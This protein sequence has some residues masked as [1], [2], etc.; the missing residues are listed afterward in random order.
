MAAVVSLDKQTIQEGGASVQVREP[1]DFYLDVTE[2]LSVAMLIC[3]KLLQPDLTLNQ[4]MWSHVY[5]KCLSNFL[6]TVEEF[7][8]HCLDSFFCRH[9]AACL[10]FLVL[11]SLTFVIFAIFLLNWPK[12]VFSCVDVVVLLCWCKRIISSRPLEE[13]FRFSTGRTIQ[14]HKVLFWCSF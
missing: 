1:L 6:E 7:D 5:I 3:A 9:P 14:S 10:I 4:V 2:Q 12:I 11:P 8:S 13:V